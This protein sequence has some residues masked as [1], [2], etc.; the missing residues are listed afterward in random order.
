MRKI[1]AFLSGFLAGA[2]LSGAIGLLLAPQSGE[3]TRASLRARIDDLLEEGR[4]A[5]ET[6]RRELEAQLASFKHG[7]AVVEE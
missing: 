3:E 5:A 7:S 1:L 4:L 6:R 2:A